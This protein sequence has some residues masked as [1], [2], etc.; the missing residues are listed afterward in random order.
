M[1][2]LKGHKHIVTLID[3]Y[4][5]KHDVH[6]V[7]ELCSGGEL[8]DRIVAEGHYSEQ[9]AASCCRDILK[10]VAH[11]HSMGVV[12][13]DLKPEN[14]LYDSKA[15][16][17]TIKATDFGLSVFFQRD[18]MLHDVVGSAFYVAPE[19]LNKKYSF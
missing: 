14:F 10:V 9:K 3:A 1:H 8:F 17:A 18:V 19:V 2:H 5:D 16:D 15:Q 4:E 13:R 12:H 11:C 6:L 7:M